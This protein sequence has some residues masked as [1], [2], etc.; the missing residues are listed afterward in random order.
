M[1]HGYSFWRAMKAACA[2]A[3]EIA[4]SGTTCFPAL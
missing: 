4:L 2:A 3:G 1:R